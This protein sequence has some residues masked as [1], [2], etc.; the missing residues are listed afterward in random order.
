MN[1][2]QTSN[3]CLDVKGG[4]V[5]KESVVDLQDAGDPVECAIAYEEHKADE[6]LLF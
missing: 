3:S 5:V 4:R 1:S 6:I 2:L